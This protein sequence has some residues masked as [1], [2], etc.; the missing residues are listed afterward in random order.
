MAFQ[1]EGIEWFFT[2]SGFVNLQIQKLHKTKR[3]TIPQ[4]QEIF[5]IIKKS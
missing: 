2:G 4:K 3:R 1:V 5:K